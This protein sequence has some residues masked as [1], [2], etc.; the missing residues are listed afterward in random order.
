MYRPGGDRDVQGSMIPYVPPNELN[1]EHA[2]NTN[3][4]PSDSSCINEIELCYYFFRN[5][6]FSK[7]LYNTFSPTEIKQKKKLKTKKLG[8]FKLPAHAHTVKILI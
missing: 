8:G 7:S 4:V 6:N 2:I 5:H 3:L 1:Y